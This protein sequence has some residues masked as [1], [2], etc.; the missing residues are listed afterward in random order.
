LTHAEIYAY[1][2][3]WLNTADGIID[4]GRIIVA[5]DEANYT[6]YDFK[7]KNV[8]AP[9]IPL[10]ITGG[11]AVDGDTGQALTLIDT[12]GGTIFM[13]A[14]HVIPKIITVSGSSAPT[15]QEIRAEIDTNSA[16]LIAIKAKT[17][18]LPADPASET[19]INAV[20]IDVSKIKKNTDL[21]PA[22]L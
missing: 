15:V 19:N 14:E 3:Y 10:V 11:W 5:K 16:K 7:I 21:I 17:D 9:S 8:T 1:E 18:N 22:T 4:E 12:S 2:T 6:Y 13:A 20:H